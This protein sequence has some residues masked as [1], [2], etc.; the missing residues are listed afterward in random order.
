M[1]RL[2]YVT[3]WLTVEGLSEHSVEDVVR[4]EGTMEVVGDDRSL[5]INKSRK[6]IY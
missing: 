2:Q 6:D 5:E 3:M 1:E 4:G